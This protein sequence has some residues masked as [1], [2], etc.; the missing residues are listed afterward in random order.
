MEERFD[1]EGNWEEKSAWISECDRYCSGAVM[2]KINL[3]KFQVLWY[4]LQAPPTDYYYKAQIQAGNGADS[5]AAFLFDGFFGL[6]SASRFTSDSM[7]A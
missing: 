7:S 3:L 1:A 4:E 5:D 2:M 6:A